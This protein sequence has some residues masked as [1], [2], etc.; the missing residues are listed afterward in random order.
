MD[1]TLHKVKGE[2]KCHDLK[3][4]NNNSTLTHHFLSLLYNTIKY[5]EDPGIT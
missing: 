4:I 3:Y 5:D 1:D 2:L